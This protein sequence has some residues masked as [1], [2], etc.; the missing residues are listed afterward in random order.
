M[1]WFSLSF[2][3]GISYLETQATH[4]SLVYRAGTV[5]TIEVMVP[6][7]Q[8]ALASKLSDPRDQ[9]IEFMIWRPLERTH[10]AKSNP[11]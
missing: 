10:N 3:I 6:L 9:M 8:L 5:V 11:K 2:L 1:Q 7:T 4:F